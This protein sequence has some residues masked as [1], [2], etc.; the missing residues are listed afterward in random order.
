MQEAGPNA[1]GGAKH[2]ATQPLE[3]GHVVE[4]YS[5]HGTFCF[6]TFFFQYVYTDTLVN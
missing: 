5:I 1:A 6:L 3:Q 4:L 2:N